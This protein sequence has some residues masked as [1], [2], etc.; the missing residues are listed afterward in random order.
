MP[1]RS[2]SSRCEPRVVRAFKEHYLRFHFNHGHS[3]VAQN[4]L[5]A[6]YF[7]LYAAGSEVSSSNKIKSSL[8][9][10]WPS[11]KLSTVASATAPLAQWIGSEIMLVES[12]KK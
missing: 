5:G 10:V 1:N 6:C 11:E 3:I 12:R 8:L 9:I 7:Q 2:T 4:K